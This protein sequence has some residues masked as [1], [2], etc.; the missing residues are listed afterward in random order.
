MRRYDAPMRTFLWIATALAA[1]AQEPASPAGAESRAAAASQPSPSASRFE[2]GQRLRELERAWMGCSDAARRTEATPLI[3]QAVQKFFLL[4]GDSTVAPMDAALALLRG[5]AATPARLWAGSVA[6]DLAPFVLEAEPVRARCRVRLLYELES[7]RPNLRLEL[8]RAPGEAPLA[9]VEHAERGG[10]VEFPLPKEEPGDRHLTATLLCEGAPIRSFAISY[11]RVTNAKERLQALSGS[12]RSAAAAQLDGETLR[13]RVR[14]LE[15]LLSGSRLETAVPFHELLLQTEADAAAVAALRPLPM[16][17]GRDLRLSV[18][19]PKGGSTPARAW[20]SSPDASV[21]VVAL[22]GAGGSANM[23]FDA[24][25]DGLIVRLARER[26]WNLV[27]PT[28]PPGGA[29]V[30]DA[31]TLL[32]Q[33]TSPKA[34]HTILVGHSMGAMTAGVLVSREPLRYLAAVEIAGAGFGDAAAAARIPHFL[35]TA[36][37]DF[38]RGQVD[39]LAR[40]LEKLGGRVEYRRYGSDHLMVVPDALPDAFR[41][42]DGLLAEAASKPASADRNK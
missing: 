39:A 14:D 34:T 42:L 17:A 22:H 38:A 10:E 9:V 32:Q 2:L 3:A 15:Q 24:Y 36:E 21:L 33:R 28:V 37:K 18:P 27:A 12:V 35:A 40:A 5:E 1:G 26:G 30:A 8:R 16:P 13:G 19:R 20:I 11:S 7:E 23:F 6:A 4:G 25:G 41:W 29:F 31:I